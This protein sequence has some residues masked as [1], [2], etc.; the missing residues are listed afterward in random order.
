MGCCEKKMLN[1][2]RSSTLF[3]CVVYPALVLF[4]LPQVQ[5]LGTDTDPRR[6]L[7]L[8]SHSYGIHPPSYTMESHSLWIEYLFLLYWE[9]FFLASVLCHWTSGEQK[10]IRHQYFCEVSYQKLHKRFGKMM[11]PC[12]KKAPSILFWSMSSVISSV[13]KCCYLFCSEVSIVFSKIIW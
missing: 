6:S 4:T 5:L 8:P 3:P 12:F 11:R 13:C 9:Y 10:F 1:I 7:V 2:F